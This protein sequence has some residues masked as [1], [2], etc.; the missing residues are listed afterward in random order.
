MDY[1][2]RVPNSTSLW[3][4][5]ELD[6]DGDGTLETSS[7]RVY[8]RHSMVHPPTSPFVVGLPGGSSDE[9]TPGMDFRIGFAIGDYGLISRFVIYTTTISILEAP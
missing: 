3:M 1:E 7:S 6:V 2:F 5:L 8:L 4:K 9:L